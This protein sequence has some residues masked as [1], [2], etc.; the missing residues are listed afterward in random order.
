M[1]GLRIYAP[2]DCIASNTS[3]ENAFALRQ[4]E[5][6]LKGTVVPSPQLTFKTRSAATRAR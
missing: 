4:I 1:R 5:T 3:E 2:A 6:V